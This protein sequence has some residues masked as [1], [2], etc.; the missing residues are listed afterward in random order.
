MNLQEDLS[1]IK[2]VLENCSRPDGSCTACAL[3][4]RVTVLLIERTETLEWIADYAV[5]EVNPDADLLAE[6]AR[7]VLEKEKDI[8]SEKSAPPKLKIVPIINQTS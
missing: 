3:L 6:K 4:A 2:F 8:Y 7:E 5:P 1:R